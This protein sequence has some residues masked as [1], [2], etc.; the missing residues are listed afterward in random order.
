MATEQFLG[1]HVGPRPE[2]IREMLQVIGVSSVEELIQQTVPESIRLKS[3]FRSI[4]YTCPDFPN[5]VRTYVF[6]RPESLIGP[7][8]IQD[9]ERDQNGSIFCQLRDGAWEKAFAF[10]KANPVDRVEAAVVFRGDMRLRFEIRRFFLQLWG[11]PVLDSIQPNSFIYLLD[12]EEEQRMYRESFHLAIR[13]LLEPVCP[14]FF[15]SFPLFRASG[16][17]RPF[18]MTDSSLKGP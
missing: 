13:Y 5:P 8:D 14:W 9:V 7:E 2:D 16:S 17:R 4:P 15:K 1:R 10:M 3:G 18:L 11:M 6:I 12:P